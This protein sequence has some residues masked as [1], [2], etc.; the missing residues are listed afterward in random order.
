M[1]TVLRLHRISGETSNRYGTGVWWNRGMMER[2]YGTEV[3]NECGPGP[4]SRLYNL[5]CTQLVRIRTCIHKRSKK[6]L[7][8]GENC[9]TDSNTEKSKENIIQNWI[10][11]Y[12]FSAAHWA[13]YIA[14]KTSKTIQLYIYVC[15]CH[16][17][18]TVH[19]Q[20]WL[21]AYGHSSHIRNPNR[22]G[23]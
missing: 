8:F 15:V 2:R 5:T 11:L 6:V 10:Y 3:W 19:G 21:T 7:T 23:T 13:S 17:W 18:V 14:A 9:W 12:L 22:M 4:F 1:P 20:I 16:C